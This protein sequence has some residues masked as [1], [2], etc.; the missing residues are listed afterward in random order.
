MFAIEGLPSYEYLEDFVSCNTVVLKIKDD[1][2]NR[3]NFDSTITFT[4]LY[5]AD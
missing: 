5:N 1:H 3:G 4:I 2:R